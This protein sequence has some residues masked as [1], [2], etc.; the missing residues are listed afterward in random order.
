MNFRM[1][2]AYPSKKVTF[3]TSILIT[4]LNGKRNPFHERRGASENGSTFSP[5][6]KPPRHHLRPSFI[7]MDPLVVYYRKQAGRGRE[8]IGTIYSIPPFVQRGHGIGSVLADIFRTL[9]PVLWSSAKSMGKKTFKALGREA[10]RTG[11]KIL[12]DIA[13]NPQ[14]KTKDIISIHVTEST[15]NIIKK[16]RGRGR[17]R[18]RASLS[19]RNAKRKKKTD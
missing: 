16:L 3:M 2:I 14:T 5:R 7:I 4:G 8:V 6:I 19:P 15:Q 12:T 10:L 1:Y 9:R 18:K 11:G 17:K 13:E